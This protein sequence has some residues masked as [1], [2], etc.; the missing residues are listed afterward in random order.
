M[1]VEITKIEWDVNRT[2]DSPLREDLRL[3]EYAKD[4]GYKITAK[5]NWH[6]SLQFQIGNIHIW[7]IR[8]G[9]RAADV[10]DG[11]FKNHRNYADLK[12]ALDS[13]WRKLTATV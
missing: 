5:R 9:V 4:L 11:Y 3:F 8:E 2:S 10:V 12:D 6:D 7:A 13:E 1:S